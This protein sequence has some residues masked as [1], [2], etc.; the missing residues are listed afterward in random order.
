MVLLN[1]LKLD[2]VERG[3]LKTSIQPCR[4]KTKVTYSKSKIFKTSRS[5]KLGV[6]LCSRKSGGRKKRKSGGKK[7]GRKV[8]RKSGS[9]TSSRSIFKLRHEKRY[10]VFAPSIW[11]FYFHTLVE[12][13]LLLQIS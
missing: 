10:N 13:E 4:I 11:L 7:S 8:K 5:H 1:D 2:D 6:L 3:E 9:K 12:A